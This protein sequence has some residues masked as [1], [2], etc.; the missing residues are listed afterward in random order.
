M[1]EWLR[2]AE[3]QEDGYDVDATLSF[4][5]AYPR[6]ADWPHRIGGAEIRPMPTL[7]GNGLEQ[8]PADHPNIVRAYELLGTW[9][10]VRRSFDRLIYRFYPLLDPGRAGRGST[11]GSQDSELGIIYA[12]VYSAEGLAEAFVHEMGHTKLRCLGIWLEKADRLITNGPEEL[13]E[14][15]IRKDKLRPMTA[16][17]HAEF[18]YTYVTA[19]DLRMQEAEPGPDHLLAIGVNLQR[20]LEGRE[21]IRCHLKVDRD[22]EHF[23]AAYIDW[24]DRT[25]E[26]CKRVLEQH[27]G[28][29]NGT[30]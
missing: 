6:E 28:G 24:L 29:E 18:S 26:E 5:P 12:T 25:L 19:L 30:D 4:V 20:L 22:G 17:V 11:C 2:V 23:F 21:V 10:A 1:I 7:P 8:A 3:P 9:P 14:S 16:V 13:F 15:P 27:K